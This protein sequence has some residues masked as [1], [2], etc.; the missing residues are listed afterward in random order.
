M[1]Y[2]TILKNPK[3]LRNLGRILRIRILQNPE[4]GFFKI[5]NYGFL[6]IND[7]DLNKI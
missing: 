5:L 6:R 1:V 4:L 2:T 7:M 3:F